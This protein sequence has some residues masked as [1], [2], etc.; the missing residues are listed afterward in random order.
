MRSD[1]NSII[2]KTPVSLSNVKVPKNDLIFE[3]LDLYFNCRYWRH[4]MAKAVIFYGTDFDP[5][6]PLP[7]PR[8]TGN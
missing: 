6:Q 7:L 1:L 2:L 3:L 4:P 8:R 5:R